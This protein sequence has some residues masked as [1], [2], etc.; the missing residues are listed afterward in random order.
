ME[1]VAEMPKQKPVTP[2]PRERKKPERKK[3][4][5]IPRKKTAKPAAKQVQKKEAS[6]PRK[7]GQQA[8]PDQ[9]KL[10]QASA[11]QQLASAGRI[12]TIE[13]RYRTLVRKEI[14][15]RKFYPARAKRQRRQGTVTVGFELARDGRIRNLRLVKKCKSAILGRAALEAVR[16][17]G[18]FPSFPAEIHRLSWSFEIPLSYRIK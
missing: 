13:D 9:R 18:L 16:K 11:A 3:P 17:V 2:K 1:A 5:P 7:T 6:S 14:E 4:Q 15:K 8:K 10:A 12:A